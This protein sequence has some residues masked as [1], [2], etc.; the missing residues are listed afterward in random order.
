MRFVERVERY[1]KESEAIRERLLPEGQRLLRKLCGRAAA[2]FSLR[3]AARLTGLSPTYL[4][5]CMNG[6]Q[7]ISPGAYLKLAALSFEDC[8]LAKSSSMKQ[9]KRA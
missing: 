2:P 7:A 5:L 8:C 1:C 9:A 6:K 4:S 3:R